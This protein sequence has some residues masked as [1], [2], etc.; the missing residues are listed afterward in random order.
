MNQKKTGY[1]VESTWLYCGGGVPSVT[2]ITSSTTNIDRSTRDW[3]IALAI[4]NN[5]LNAL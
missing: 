1:V 4:G 3:P 5:N 2:V